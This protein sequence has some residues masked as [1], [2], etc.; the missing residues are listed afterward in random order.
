MATATGQERYGL[1]CT[2]TCAACSLATSAS[3]ASLWEQTLTYSPSA[4]DMAP[5]TSPERPD[6]ITCERGRKAVRKV[7][8]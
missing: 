1:A 2:R 3:S 6:S 5:P 7:K 4:I 8:R